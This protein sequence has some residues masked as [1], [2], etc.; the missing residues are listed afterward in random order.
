MKTL[1]NKATTKTSLERRYGASETTVRKWCRRPGWPGGEKGPWLFAKVDSALEEMGSPYAPSHRNGTN[2]RILKTTNNSRAAADTA[3][4]LLIQEQYRKIKLENDILE[5]KLVYLDDME[6]RWAELILWIKN[7][8][9]GL[10]DRV[11]R[12]FPGKDRAQV[13]EEVAE[14]IRR[15]LRY[16]AGLEVTE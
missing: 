7:G 10:P 9:E 3:K 14:E 4:A 16:M 12:L 5:K 1:V 8:A 11:A 6:R 15:W 2:G 13:I